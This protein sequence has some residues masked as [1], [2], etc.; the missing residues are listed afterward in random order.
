M[1][2]EYNVDIDDIKKHVVCIIN[3]LHTVQMA[4]KQRLSAYGYGRCDVAHEILLFINH[5]KKGHSRPD[6]MN[7]NIN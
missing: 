2:D 3:E 4:N 7:N 6:P 5:S 1:E